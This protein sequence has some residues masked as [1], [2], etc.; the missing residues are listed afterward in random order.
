MYIFVEIIED[1][2]NICVILFD[3]INLDVSKVLEV[4]MCTFV[5][6]SIPCYFYEY[7]PKHDKKIFNI[8]WDVVTF[9]CVYILLLT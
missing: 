9:Y 3:Y 7:K 8:L 5:F 2:D 6:E 1:L 4:I